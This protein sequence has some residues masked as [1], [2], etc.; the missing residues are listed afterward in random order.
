MQQQRLV[1]QLERQHHYG[2]W[3]HHRGVDLASSRLALWLVRGGMLWL[4][5]DC[6]CGKTHYLNALACEHPQLAL[7]RVQHDAQDTSVKQ[8]R[9]W[10]EQLGHAAYWALDVDA[11]AMPRGTALALYH[12]I[13]YAKSQGKALLIAWRGDA[14]VMQGL[15]PELCTRLHT[16]ERLDMLAPRDDADL[17]SILHSVADSLQWSVKDS[18]LKTLVA[19]YSRSLAN[20]LQALRALETASLSEHHPRRPGGKLTSDKAKQALEDVELLDR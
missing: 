5:S 3:V 7:I 14:E 12:L 18:V 4:T 6:V 9:A 8:V 17:L 1:P 13:E 15:P 16:F 11:G 19:E 20:Q 2:N 10:L